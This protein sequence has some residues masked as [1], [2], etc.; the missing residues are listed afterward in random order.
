MTVTG[1]FE[2]L[3]NLKL[4]TG[5]R[6]MVVVTIAAIAPFL[7]VGLVGIRI[8]ASPSLPMG[9]YEKTFD[10]HATLVEFCPPEPYARIALERGYRSSG[11]CPDGAE[12]LMKP[13][14]AIAGDIVDVSARGLA[15]NGVLLPNTAPKTKDTRDRPMRLWHYGRYRV[16]S[17]SVWVASSYNAWS[18]DSRY[19]G[20]IPV[21]IIRNR[22]KP[23]LTL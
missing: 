2:R 10:A 18:F 22:L 7:I 12:P 16:A 1:L 19:F 17:D 20:P 13:L 5:K 8:N 14:I 23:I 9:L 11:N 3:R 21:S 6:V 4:S 15:V